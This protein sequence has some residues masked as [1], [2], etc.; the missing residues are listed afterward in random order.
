MV[1]VFWKKDWLMLNQ[2]LIVICGMA[3]E[4]CYCIR[5]VFV[6]KDLQSKTY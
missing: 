6:E 2:K 4:N 3:V 5:D 1:R